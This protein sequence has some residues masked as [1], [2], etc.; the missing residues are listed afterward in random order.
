MRFHP[1][2]KPV[3]SIVKHVGGLASLIVLVSACA[4][5]PIQE[6]SNA[7]QSVQAA[8]EAGAGEFASYNL[9]A[10]RDYLTRAERE[11]ELRYFSRARHDAIV[12]KSEARKAHEVAQA[13][14]QAQATLAVSEAD[15]EALAEARTLLVEAMDAARAG[16]DRQAIRLARDAERRAGAVATLG[17]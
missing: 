6:M 12:A 16:R 2:M 14:Q 1:A 15:E 5:A 3:V 8:H 13:L 9:Q 10:A 4:T 17:D 11:L 7:R